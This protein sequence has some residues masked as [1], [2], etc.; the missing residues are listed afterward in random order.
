MKNLIVK[1]H[2]NIT[3]TVSLLI[4]LGVIIIG[5]ACNTIYNNG[6]PSEIF[7]NINTII[8]AIVAST[9]G[10]AQIIKKESPLGGKRTIKGKYAIVTGW[11]WICFCIFIIGISFYSI[12]FET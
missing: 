4:A 10:V 8:A 12:F 2:I 9:G 1:A 3:V 5:G 11:F 6:N 7:R